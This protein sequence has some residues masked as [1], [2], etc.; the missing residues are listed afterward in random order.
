MADQ[1]AR[2][3]QIS[4]ITTVY[5]AKDYLPATVQSILGQTFTDFELLLV[6]DGSP[7]GCGAL[8]DELAEA[9]GR[10]RVIHKKNGG[11][12]SAANA[13]L[14][15]ARGR[16][17][18]Y[19]DSDDLVRPE[20]LETLHR[21]A[22]ESGCP[23]AACGAECIDETGRALGRGVTVAQDLLG[24]GDAL[25]QFYDVLRDGGMYCMVTWNKLYDARLFEGVRHDESMFYGDDAN[26]MDKIYDGRAIFASNEPLYLYRVRTGSMTALDFSAKKLDDLRLDGGWADFFAQKPGRA[27]LYQWALA[28]YWRVFYLFYVHARQA[29]PLSQ[30]LKAGFA[31]HKKTLN[32]L[33]WPILRCRHLAPG[34]KLRAALIALS[35][36]G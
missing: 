1:R 6:D 19:I 15:A 22:A 13:G 20:F 17:I 16:Y 30:A 33:L 7:N 8:C 14:D 27:D 11:P 35:P 28:R 12:A 3:P 5:D 36:E 4:V 34:E 24:K 32:R 10:I 26:I 9:D 18:S 25:D 31:A 29:G 21:M 2:R 23:L